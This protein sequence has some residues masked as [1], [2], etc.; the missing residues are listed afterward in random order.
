MAQRLFKQTKRKCFKQKVYEYHVNDLDTSFMQN[1]GITQNWWNFFKLVNHTNNKFDCDLAIDWELYQEEM[2]ILLYESIAE[3]YQS[4]LNLRRQYLDD[5]NAKLQ[6][7]WDMDVETL[8]S[9]ALQCKQAG[10][11]TDDDQITYDQEIKFYK[12]YYERKMK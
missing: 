10:A 6:A 7:D 8:D 5:Y 2:S 9:W 1:K 12:E 4:Y 11:F 3:D